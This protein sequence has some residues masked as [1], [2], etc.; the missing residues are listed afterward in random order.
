[1]RRRLRHA[2]RRVWRILD[3]TGRR[4]EAAVRGLRARFFESMWREAATA[5]G[6]GI[7]DVGYGFFR[8]SRGPRTTFVRDS[9]VMLDDHLSL[10]IAGNKPLVY[11]LLARSGHPVPRFAEFDLST[12]DRAERFLAELARPV[13]VKPA[14]GT[15]GGAGVTTHVE[16]SRALRRAAHLA[17]AFDANLVVEQ[18]VTGDSYRLLYLD[19]Q[20]IDAIRR[21]PPAVA[22]DGRRTI[23]ALVEAE[24]AHRL[25]AHPP[26]ALS[27]IRLDPDCRAKLRHQGLRLGS[28]PAPGQVVPVKHVVNQNSARENHV[29]RDRVH[30]SIVT[31]G[32]RAVSSLGLRLAGVDV[33]TPNIA[34]PLPD[35]GGVI[36]EINTTPGLHHHLLVARP[37]ERVPV[38]AMILEY[39]LSQPPPGDTAHPG[40]GA[41][42]HESGSER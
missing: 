34:A 21:D 32:R 41:G 4:R 14:S 19:G 5:L 20:C 2:Y 8:I 23:Q 36:N 7:E 1:M 39:I 6:A 27:L 26:S 30:P 24:N 42:R 22:G 31:L 17:D 35:T 15:G 3:V 33:L 12:L 16:T 28:V 9:D 10:E 13:V 29:V 25:A 18:Q 40:T 37:E 38:P 11:R